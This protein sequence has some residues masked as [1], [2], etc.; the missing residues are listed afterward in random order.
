MTTDKPNEVRPLTLSAFCKLWTCDAEI[1]QVGPFRYVVWEPLNAPFPADAR[2]SCCYIS[3]IVFYDVT[4][5][6]RL[7][8]CKCHAINSPFPDLVYLQRHNV[9]A[10]M[11]LGTVIHREGVGWCVRREA[12]TNDRYA[13]SINFGWKVWE[14]LNERPWWMVRVVHWGNWHTWRHGVIYWRGS[15]RWEW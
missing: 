14:G 2:P 4:G 15:P 10:T 12:W 13:R 8:E 9:W 5:N 3:D 7:G 1:E 6:K 11:G